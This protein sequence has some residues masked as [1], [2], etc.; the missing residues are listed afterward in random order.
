[1]NHQQNKLFSLNLIRRNV[2]FSFSQMGSFMFLVEIY[3]YGFPHP[4]PILK[5]FATYTACMPGTLKGDIS[6]CANNIEN[7]NFKKC[8]FSA[9]MQYYPLAHKNILFSI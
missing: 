6:S 1:M 2:E 4:P 3:F 9:L 5:P 8:L 7:K